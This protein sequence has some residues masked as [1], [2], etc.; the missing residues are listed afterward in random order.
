MAIVKSMV[1]KTLEEREKKEKKQ[2]EAG[3]NEV[4][5][6]T[7]L[8]KFLRCSKASVHN[9]KHLG[10]PFYR[11]GRKILFKKSEVL[12]FMKTLKGKNFIV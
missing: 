8:G 12:L 4:L 6:I 2:E 11:V 1:E 3:E 5:N 9:Y 7:E 10:L